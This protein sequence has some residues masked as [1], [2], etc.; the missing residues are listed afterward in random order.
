MDERDWYQIAKSSTA[1]DLSTEVNARKDK[2]WDLFGSPY[3]VNGTY[4]QAVIKRSGDPKRLREAFG[5]R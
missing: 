1:S 5:D 3:S 2:G 4:C